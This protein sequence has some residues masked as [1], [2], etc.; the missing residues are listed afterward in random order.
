MA[1]PEEV[2][3]AAKS[4]LNSFPLSQRTHLG[5][6]YRQTMFSWNQA[7]MVAAFK[8]YTGAA[9]MN[10]VKGSTA[11]IIAVDPW[12]VAGDM[13]V[14]QSKHH[15]KNGATSLKVGWR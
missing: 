1:I 8:S 4:A 14:I 3:Y 9:S 6:P 7:A 2:Q 13:W 15:A 10:F 11:T 12:G 5:T